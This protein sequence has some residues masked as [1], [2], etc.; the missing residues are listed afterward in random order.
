MSAV[1]EANGKTF[2]PVAVEVIA[3]PKDAVPKFAPAIALRMPEIVVE[4]VTAR[5]V[6]VA[7]IAVNPPLNAIEV[8]VALFGNG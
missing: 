1:D 3:P 4:P 5:A 8:V 2:A 6:E 7:P